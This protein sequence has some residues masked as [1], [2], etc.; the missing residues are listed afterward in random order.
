MVGG[1]SLIWAIPNNVI[2]FDLRGHGES[3]GDRFSLGYFEKRDVLGAIR[4]LRDGKKQSGDK[5]GVL[6]FSMG[7]ASGLLASTETDA[8]GAIVADSS[9][10]QLRPILDVKLP[11]E[12]PLPEWVYSVL[13][14]TGA[15]IMMGRLM[16]DIDLN[17]VKPVE[18]VRKL[19]K[20]PILFIH[21]A[22]DETIPVAHARQLHKASPVP[23]HELWVC[24]NVGHV[25]CYDTYPEEYK[26]R[27][28][29][30]FDK[31]LKGG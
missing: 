7:A 1:I 15:T 23:Q 3:D 13:P 14:L 31:Y 6:G 9:F 24:G 18:A 27:I 26:R 29:E 8:I 28:L 25:D 19:D 22:D 30:F 12:S 5:I 17:A 4:Y 20:T 11:E 21:G 10:A 2:L 16:F